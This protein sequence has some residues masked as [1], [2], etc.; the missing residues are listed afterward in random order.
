MSSPPKA[1]VECVD[2]IMSPGEKKIRSPGEKKIRSTG[3]LKKNPKKNLSTV[4][5]PKLRSSTH[6]RVNCACDR[7]C[8]QTEVNYYFRV[9]HACY[10]THAQVYTTAC[11]S[12]LRPYSYLFAM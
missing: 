11:T 9:N 1:R 6:F 5:V 4:V 7:A 12:L 3:D 2:K 10:H 8:P